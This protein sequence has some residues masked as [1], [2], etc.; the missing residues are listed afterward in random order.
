MCPVAETA[1]GFLLE[2]DGM[3]QREQI[4]AANI[5]LTPGLFVQDG[6]VAGDSFTHCASAAAINMHAPPTITA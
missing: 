3:F 2:A 4:H 1:T 6:F 5:R